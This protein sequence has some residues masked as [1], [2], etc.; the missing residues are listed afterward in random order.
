MNTFT[1][2]ILPVLNSSEECLKVS[3]LNYEEVQKSFNDVFNKLDGRLTD[4]SRALTDKIIPG[5]EN[6]SDVIRQMFNT[7]FA[8]ELQKALS[9]MNAD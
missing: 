3:G 4:L 9:I 5:Y 2:K 1:S 6:A 7:E 8:E